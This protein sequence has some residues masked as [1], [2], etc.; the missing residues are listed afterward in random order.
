MNENTLNE[1]KDELGYL[2][3]LK[4]IRYELEFQNDMKVMEVLNDKAK[5]TLGLE[6]GLKV[7]ALEKI[8]LDK[9]YKKAISRKDL[10]VIDKLATGPDMYEYYKLRENGLKEEGR[11]DDMH[12]LFWKVFHKA[13]SGY[14]DTLEAKEYLRTVCRNSTPIEDESKVDEFWAKA[15]QER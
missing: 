3:V 12:N 6:V 13:K 4:G 9:I 15:L 1:I 5:K 11:L 7:Q 8:T 14:I 2:A 10:G